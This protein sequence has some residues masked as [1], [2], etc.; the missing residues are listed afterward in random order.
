[1][2]SRGQLLDEVHGDDDAG[3]E[4]TIDSHVKRLRRKLEAMAPGFDPVDAVYG[5][6]YRFREPG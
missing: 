1:V 4:R 5:A 6:G 2:R 3:S